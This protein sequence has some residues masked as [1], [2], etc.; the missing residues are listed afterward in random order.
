MADAMPALP[1]K[2]SILIIFLLRGWETTYS[3]SEVVKPVPEKADCAWN[4]AIS[5]DNPVISNATLPILITIMENR[6]TT[7]QGN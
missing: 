6:T 1:I 2:I 4:A 5:L 3:D 7:Q